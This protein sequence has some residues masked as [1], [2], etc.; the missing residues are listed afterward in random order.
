MIDF[1]TGATRQGTTL[2]A[3]EASAYDSLAAW[4]DMKRVN[5]SIEYSGVNGENTNQNPGNC[6]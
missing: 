3:D 4:Y 2:H 1:V 6:L 5:H